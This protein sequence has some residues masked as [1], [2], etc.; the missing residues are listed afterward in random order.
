[1]KRVITKQEEFEILKMVLDKFLWL[2]LFI[3][4]YGF[5]RIIGLNENFWYGFSILIAGA[6]LLL[7]FVWILIKEYNYVKR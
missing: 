4:A 3:M 2:G 1:M 6:I 7:L 5:Y